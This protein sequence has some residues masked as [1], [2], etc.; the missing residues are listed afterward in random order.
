MLKAPEGTVTAEWAPTTD[1]L[2]RDATPVVWSK[3]I[4]GDIRVVEGYTVRPHCDSGGW[5]GPNGQNFTLFIY[6]G[7]VGAN[8]TKFS[9]IFALEVEDAIAPV[10]CYRPWT[11]DG[12]LIVI[13]SEAVCSAIAQQRHSV[14]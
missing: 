3:F 11:D 14:H 7:T 4:A 5:Y 13:V 6:S 10:S 1:F 9:E 8:M 2:P 12:L